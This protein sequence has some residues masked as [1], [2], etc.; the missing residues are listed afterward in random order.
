MWGIVRFRPGHKDPVIKQT[1]I[2]ESKKVFFV[3]SCLDIW[4]ADKRLDS[5]DT[6]GRVKE[7]PPCSS[8]LL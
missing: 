5:L 3:M 6:M 2:L 1:G 7:I 4:L 8:D